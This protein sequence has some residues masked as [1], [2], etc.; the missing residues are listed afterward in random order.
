MYGLSDITLLK[1]G[2]Y[3]DGRWCQADSLEKL[4]VTNPATG[5]IIG[6][7]PLCG[8]EETKRAILAA[9]AA[10]DG[11]K[12]LSPNARAQFLREWAYL[13][14]IHKND[15][16]LLITLEE[17][18]PLAEAKGEVNY[19]NDYIKWFAEE[20]RRAYGDVLP[21]S[22]QAHR[23]FVFKEPI[24]AVAA[25]TTW[26]FPI[27]MMI[28]K[29][30][31]ALAA[32]C[33]VV[34]KPDEKTPL[35]MYALTYLAEK[36]G[37][38]P[39]VLNV[40]TGNPNEIG[41][42]MTESPL[43]QKISF[44]GSTAIGKQLMAQSASTVKKLS[45]ELGGNAPFI[46]FD[47]ANVEAAVKGAIA[48]KF[49]NSGQTCVCANRIYIQDSIYARF[50]K[51]FVHAANQLKVG[52]GLEPGVQQGPLIHE[53]A[54]AKV[55]RHVAD[56]IEK[57]AT[58]LCGGK[59]HQLGGLFF[60]PTVLAHVNHSMLIAQEET[61]GPVAPLF[62]F[63]TE[64]EVIQYANDTPFGLSAYFFSENVH[65][66]RRITEALQYGIVGAN[67]GLT[68]AVEAPFGGIKQSGHGREGSH[69][70]L[71]DYLQIKY[72]CLGGEEG[73]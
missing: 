49:R 39:G 18:K 40:L 6:H 32:G 33:T 14:E 54:L 17:G 1:T 44:T 21:S 62:R 61:F 23:L 9:H 59:S 56:A 66:V 29:I 19:A 38:P 26:N 12:K 11:W 5:E 34:A 51:A 41:A 8:K 72:V 73:V 45:L 7:V 4:A 31:P 71:L 13:I 67:T 60:E 20:A 37:L 50:T 10:F 64:E 28:R 63:E 55:K 70:G 65:R 27:A 30:S 53:Q 57:G 69:Y 52:N 36:A 58:V 25:I 48:S 24:G 43:I 46:I 42:A 3:I 35:S 16:A 68:S 22:N 15:L 47:D 2:C